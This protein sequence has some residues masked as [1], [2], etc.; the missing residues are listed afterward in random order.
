[1][2]RAFSIKKKSPTIADWMTT[3]QQM[4]AEHTTPPRTRGKYKG[5][6]STDLHWVHDLVDFVTAEINKRRGARDENMA[7]AS[8]LAFILGQWYLH[9]HRAKSY[10]EN[11]PLELR[12]HAL[13][14]RNKWL[15]DFIGCAL[16]DRIMAKVFPQK[17]SPPF[18]KG[19]KGG[20]FI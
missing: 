10:D 17:F 13:R 19:A 7:V 15:E 14:T 12:R 18:G 1:M 9:V 6:G 8:Y 4:I 20:K 3:I 16:S 5:H 11:R 2:S